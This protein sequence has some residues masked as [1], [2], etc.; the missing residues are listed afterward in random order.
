M[1]TSPCRK[2]GCEVVTVKKY[3]CES[4]HFFHIMICCSILRNALFFFCINLFSIPCKAKTNFLKQ[5]RFVGN[6]VNCK[7]IENAYQR[8]NQ[9]MWSKEQK[10]VCVEAQILIRSV[11]CIILT[12]KKFGNKQN[13]S[14]SRSSSQ[15]EQ[16]GEM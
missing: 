15:A 13:C 16:S 2:N 11:A 10:Q 3:S 12:W 6:L 8:K 7:K 5:S 9:A 4:I 14:K 1:C